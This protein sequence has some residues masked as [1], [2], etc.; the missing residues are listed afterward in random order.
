MKTINTINKMKTIQTINTMKKN[1][2]LK[3][4]G[5]LAFMALLTTQTNAQTAVGSD[6]AKGANTVKVI[7]NKG[8]IKYLQANNGITQITNTTGDVTTT[9]WQLGGTLTDDTYIDA[10]GKV[11]G[12]KGLDITASAAS[13]DGVAAGYTLL[14][15]DAVTGKVQ[16]LLAT[17]LISAGVN[18][19]ALTE[20]VGAGAYTTTLI[21]GLP[22]VSN[23]ISVFRNGIKL[24]QTSSSADWTLG[25][26]GNAGKIV[27]NAAA[28]ALY[29]GDVIEVQ[30]VN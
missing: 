24:R 5:V 11:F 27:F 19:V 6:V 26:E 21:T 15:N 30:W 2:L 4:F 7:D 3:A 22:T 28:G 14:V 20:N 8:T 25:V 16:R 29:S 18:E 12:L 23:R 13:A 1:Y 17:S 9:T 10:T